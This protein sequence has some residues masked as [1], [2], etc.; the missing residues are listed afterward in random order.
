MQKLVDIYIVYQFVKRLTTPFEKTPAFKLGIIDNQGNVLRPLSALK[1][2]E[3]KN[4]WTWFDILI[5]N[6]KRMLAKIPGGTSKLFTYL[7]AFWLLREPV[8]KLREAAAWDEALLTETILGPDSQQ[9]LSEASALV[10]ED[11]PAMATG[12]GAVAG[13]G[14]GPQGEPGV[15]LPRSRKRRRDIDEDTKLWKY[16]KR[17]GYWDLQRSIASPHDEQT[18]LKTFQDDEPTEHFVISKTRP[19]KKPKL[20]EATFAGCEVFEVD[21]D[22][23]QRSRLGKKKFDRYRTYVGTA[24]MGETIRQYGRKYGHRGIILRDQTTGAMMFLRRPGRYT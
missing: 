2:S 15:M 6:I 7:A 13:L 23:F 20:Q 12:H 16:N 14:V 21:S 18:W 19:S 4:A 5:N 22:T 24:Q 3:E 9:Y 17:S 10:D 11:A 1:T 8:K